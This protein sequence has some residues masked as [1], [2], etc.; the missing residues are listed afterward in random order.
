[1]ET[2]ELTVKDSGWHVS[3][4][5]VMACMNGDC[6]E[7]EMCGHL[8]V[9]EPLVRGT[10]FKWIDGHF[11]GTATKLENAEREL[12]REALD[13]EAAWRKKQEWAESGVE[14]RRT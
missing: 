9:V 13:E 3:A 12:E 7:R 5:H 10:W 4:H 14:R 1:M 2:N 8:L 11:R 6:V